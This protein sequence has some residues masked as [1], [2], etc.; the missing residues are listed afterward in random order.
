M[1]EFESPDD[2]MFITTTYYASGPNR[3]TKV[4]KFWLALLMKS[5]KSKL[6]RRASIL[7]FKG[8]EVHMFI[9]Y[10]KL[11]ENLKEIYI[12]TV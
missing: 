7:L 5:H 12:R 8:C 9:T 11:T 10:N 3:Q 2:K 6:R 4:P 1:L